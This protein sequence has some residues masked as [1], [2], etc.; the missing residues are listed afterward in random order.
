MIALVVAAALVQVQPQ[1]VLTGVGRWAM[2]ADSASITADGDSAV[3]MRSLQ[4]ADADFVIGDKSYW[5]GWSW[6]R[7]DCEGRTGQRLD[8]ASLAADGTEGPI[9]PVNGAPEPLAPG[10]DA[11]E[12]AA[13]AC[14]AALP[15]ADAATAE[16]AVRLGRARLND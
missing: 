16:A 10:G 2:F 12:L 5:G 7:F 14:A 15:A 3:R 13:V 1:L 11:A 9:T 6:W 4:V 8:F